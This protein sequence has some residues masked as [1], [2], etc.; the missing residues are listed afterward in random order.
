[1]GQKLKN[2]KWYE[3]KTSFGYLGLC[4][5]C[6]TVLLSQEMLTPFTLALL[7]FLV[8]PSHAMLTD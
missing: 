8:G 5:L 2:E 7:A 3:K 6:D 1:M 4:Q